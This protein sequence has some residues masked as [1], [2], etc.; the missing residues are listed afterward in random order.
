MAAVL[1]ILLAAALLLGAVPTASA[2]GYPNRP[3]R[4][5]VGFPAG[6]PT[7]VIAR[8]VSQK[9]SDALGQQFFVENVGGAGGNTAS[10]QVARATPDGYT[11]MVVST[12][13]VVN[14][15]L[16]AKVPYDAVKDFAPVTL[17]AVSPNVVVVNPSVPAKSLP[18]LV[19]LIRDNPGKY[20]FAG[21][22]VGSTP[23]LGGELFRL[24]FSLD[25]V[26]VPFTGA[27][28]AIQSTVG[29]H[30][31]IAFT[32]LPPALSAVQAGQLR[33]LGV[34]A[35]ERAT[36]LPEV[37]TFAEQGIKDQEAD[38]ITGI[39]AP[40]GTPKEIVD[41]LYREIAKAVG[42]ADVKERLTA[43]GFKPVANRPEEFGARIKLEMEKWG[44]VVRDAKLRIE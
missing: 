3:V 2:Q 37:Q 11:L 6:G 25:L 36:Q 42:Q 13:F 15:S 22:G 10:G 35:S 28:P 31:P 19:Q 12:G 38:T 5:V 26:H 23:H 9:L 21:P 18:E 20:G 40:A 24:A 29:G 39:L 34:A 30:T 14:P 27:A 7:D 16:Y 32:A 4:V 44:K 8:M 1:Q 33:A 43:L 41:L 17:V